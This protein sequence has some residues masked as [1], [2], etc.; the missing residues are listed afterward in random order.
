MDAG[1]V[2]FSQIWLTD[3]AS[4]HRVAS[5]TFSRTEKLQSVSWPSKVLDS[6]CE[7]VFSMSRFTS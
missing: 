5:P 1:S 4:Q 6:D 7:P 2:R 3:A